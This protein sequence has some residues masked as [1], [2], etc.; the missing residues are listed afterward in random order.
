MK[1]TG[2][3]RLLAALVAAVMV[4]GLLA[5]TGVFAG[6]ETASVYASD[7]VSDT[8]E[9]AGVAA[10]EGDAADVNRDSSSGEISA[11]NAEIA[12]ASP[13]VNTGEAAPETGTAAL[14]ANV[15]GAASASDNTAS[16]ADNGASSSVSKN[17][18]SSAN[19]VASSSASAEDEASTPFH[20][21]ITILN[22]ENKPAFTFVIDADA[23]VFPDGTYAVIR[24]ILANPASSDVSD[25]AVSEN[26]VVEDALLEETPEYKDIEEKL[27]KEV[28]QNGKTLSDFT[29]YDISFYNEESKDA[30]G[31]LTA[32]EPSHGVNGNKAVKVSV[33]YAGEESALS[34]DD[35]AEVSVYHLTLGEDR[36][37]IKDVKELDTEKQTEPVVDTEEETSKV[38]VAA[39][40]K[41]TV[42]VDGG[43]ISAAEW[44]VDEFSVFAIAAQSVSTSA[45]AKSAPRKVIK[46]N[47]NKMTIYFVATD[48]SQAML[49][50]G[51]S[52]IS[53]L[54]N[55]KYCG[56]FLM[57]KYYVKDII[58]HK[59]LK[60]TGQFPQYFVADDHDP[61]VPKEVWYQTQGELLRRSC[62]KRD[63]TKIRFGST[64]ALSGRLFC[65]L[66]GRTLKRYTSEEP[67]DITWKC[68][69][70]SYKKGE[71]FQENHEKCR[72][73]T[74]PE[75]EAKRAVVEAF[76]QLPERREELIRMQGS[77]RDGEI[78]GLDRNIESVR[79]Q[80]KRM[81][82][83][84]AA[85]GDEGET[86]FLEGEISRLEEEEKKLL[87]ERADAAGRE[88]QVRLLLELIGI[89]TPATFIDD[90]LASYDAEHHTSASHSSALHSSA[91]HSSASHTSAP[92]TS[93][94]TSSVDE[95]DVDSPA[96]RDYEDFFRRTRY[97]PE[98]GL[99]GRDGKIKYFSDDMVIRFLEKV[100]VTDEG[101]EVHFKA[102]VV[103]TVPA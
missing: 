72:C 95:S 85:S 2:L 42:N 3:K 68:R 74:V 17:A 16:S 69:K 30:D 7:A 79:S 32:I 6:G 83:R 12:S 4:T 60:N 82:E 48:E 88:I 86:A 46:T 56:D 45:K 77:L 33:E 47:D 44:T 40:D 100:V 22:N 87:L 101:Y 57:Q 63:P 13:S 24:P 61:I 10:G 28:A 21:E 58:S 37:Q 73:K 1:K 35:D 26:G 25:Q 98:L 29:A 43:K 62:L 93:A 49:N 36:T 8:A 75:M 80:K 52:I 31:K 50:H 102:K 66:C 27:D 11:R 38:D 39:V 19:N 103:I 59:T 9:L 15:N 41:A 5:G 65:G 20:Q 91:P 71:K 23:G 81:E 64:M 14:S 34:L 96:C 18:G 92:H 84:L 55:E 90:I 97:R 53:I 94:D 99:I 67:S 54:Q 70:R 89:M 51:D 78:K 76:N